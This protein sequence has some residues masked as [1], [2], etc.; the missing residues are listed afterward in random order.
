MGGGGRRVA[1]PWRNGGQVYIIDL[2]KITEEF[3]Q[4]A[5][6]SRYS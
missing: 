5:R 6:G 1:W 2:T 4:E 3:Q